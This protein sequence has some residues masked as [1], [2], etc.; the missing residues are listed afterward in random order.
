MLSGRCEA[1]VTTAV[2]EPRPLAA[3]AIGAMSTVLA[4]MELAAR[5]HTLDRFGDFTGQG[6][7]LNGSDISIVTNPLLGAGDAFVGW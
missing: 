6:Y 2:F 1:A 4:T 5:S 3:C 7:W